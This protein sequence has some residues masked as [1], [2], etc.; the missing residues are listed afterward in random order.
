[1]AENVVLLVF[2]QNFTN[3]LIQRGWFLDKNLECDAGGAVGGQLEE[4]RVGILS[5]DDYKH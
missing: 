3:H 2:G 4:E 5:W 1:M